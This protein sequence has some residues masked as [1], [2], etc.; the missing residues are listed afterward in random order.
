MFLAGGEI[1]LRYK[2]S[3]SFL[4]QT[5]INKVEIYWQFWV[6]RRLSETKVQQAAEWVD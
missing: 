6:F 5:T 4:Q 2:K 3:H 1:W